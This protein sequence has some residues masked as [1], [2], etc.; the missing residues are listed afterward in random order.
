MIRDFVPLIRSRAR[1]PRGGI[2]IST[3]D[4]DMGGVAISIN[5]RRNPRARRMILRVA[6]ATGEVTVTVPARTTEAAALAFARDKGDWIRAQIAKLP[7]PVPFNDGARV[8]V[9]GT[10]HRIRHDAGTT[11]GVVVVGDEIIVGGPENRLDDRVH[12]WL[13]RR[14][15]E[16]ISAKVTD[17]AAHLGRSFG[18]ITLRDTRSRWGSCSANGNLSF[19][20]RLIMAPPPVLDYVVAHE[21][22]HLA[23]RNHGSDFWTAVTT[24]AP[25][26]REARTWLS[27]HGAGL[28]A[29]GRSPNHP[30]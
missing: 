24:L 1:R 7:E 26:T 22:A 6:A 29:Y 14:A 5:I 3:A 18:R 28:L 13:K 15:R 27:K 30:S 9:L 25:D 20:W 4:L 19:S 11:P 16:E 23:V 8:P 17:K 12:A 2:A 10:L 21:V